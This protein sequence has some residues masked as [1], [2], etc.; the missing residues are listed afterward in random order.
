MSEFKVEIVRVGKIGK[1][2]NADTLSVT[3]VY[4][5]PVVFRTGDLAEG[6]LAIYCPVDSLVPTD[7]PDFAFLQ[8]DL[9]KTHARIK[10]KKLRGIFS[11]GLLIPYGYREVQ[12]GMEE[13]ANVAERLGI[14]KYE[15]EV[16]MHWGG[17]NEK[18]VEFLPKYTDIDHHRR[19]P[20]VIPEG[21]DVVITEKIHGTNSRFT[22]HEGRLWVGSHNCIK[23]ED[24]N[25]LWWRIAEKYE[26]AKKLA[27]FPGHVLYGE[28]FGHVQDLKYDAQGPNDVW[29]RIFDVFSWRIGNYVGH[30]EAVKIVEELGLNFVP[31]FYRGPWKIPLLSLADGKTEVGGAKHIREGIVIKPTTERRDDHIGRVILKHVS[32]AYLTRKSGTEFH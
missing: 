30:D 25:S 4:D 16:P 20:N 24:S 6:D 1:H 8:E 26:L 3:H 29:L 27:Q 19:Y 9:K 7:R 5:Y 15:P 12:P 21:E 10:A 14:V 11:M 22:F 2:P 28:V 18:D 31:V 13:G 17:Q 23:R 32:E